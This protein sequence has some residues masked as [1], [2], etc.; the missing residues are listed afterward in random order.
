MYTL[1][2]LFGFLYYLIE[3]IIS[4]IRWP[5]LSV[6]GLFRKRHDTQIIISEKGKIEIGKNVCFQRD[7]SISS[8]GGNLHIG[9]NVAFNRHCIAVCRN[10]IIISDNV[11]MGPGVTIYDHDHIFTFEGIQ[12]GFK[13]GSIIIERGC[14]IAANV[15]ILRDTHI[16][17]GCVIGAGV[18][19]QGDIPAHSLV[20]GNRELKI[21]PLIKA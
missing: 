9:G 12:Q 6:D 18:V 21:V 11:I 19:V 14:W 4:R 17:E 20:T 15:T 10:E 8:V 3:T 13:L 2:R 5:D 7:V 16:G 1:T